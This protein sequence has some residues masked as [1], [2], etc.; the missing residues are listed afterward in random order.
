LKTL[1]ISNLIFIF[2]FIHTVLFGEE[3]CLKIQGCSLDNKGRCIDCVWIDNKKDKEVEIPTKRRKRSSYQ[4]TVC[5]HWNPITSDE[6]EP[7]CR[8]VSSN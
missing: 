8:V 3:V 6:P 7:K 2:L 4:I 1:I 5:D